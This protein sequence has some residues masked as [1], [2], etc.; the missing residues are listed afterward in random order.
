MGIQ[1]KLVTKGVTIFGLLFC[2][3]SLASAQDLTNS[4][5]YDCGSG[6]NICASSCDQMFPARGQRTI[7]FA[8]CVHNCGVVYQW[9]DSYN[10]QLRLNS[11]SKIPRDLTNKTSNFSITIPPRKL[12]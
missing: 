3:T 6:F 1:L 7:R 4:V 2:C 8:E 10:L 9:C 5:E 12:R 11:Y